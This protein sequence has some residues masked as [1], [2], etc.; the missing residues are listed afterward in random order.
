MICI[1]YL[2]QR[3]RIA[4]PLA[5]KSAH[6]SKAVG[7]HYMGS[8]EF[9]FGA[10]PKSLRRIEARADSWICRIVNDIKEGDTPLRV[11]SALT[12]EEFAEYVGYLKILRASQSDRTVKR[13]YTKESVQFEF[14]RDRTQDEYFKTDFWWDITNDVMF[15]FKK[16]FMKRVGSYVASS[17]AYMD[18]QKGK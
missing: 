13:F 9:E 5:E 8:A 1:P 14:D 12:D 18:E 6:L 17:I 2:I 15:G 4:T 11:W 10:L 7:F 16:E 3:A